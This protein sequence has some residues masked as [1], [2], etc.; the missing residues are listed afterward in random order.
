MFCSIPILD[1]ER[2]RVGVTIHIRGIL[3]LIK[4]APDVCF[5]TEALM[6]RDY[7]VGQATMGIVTHPRETT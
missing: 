2:T 6:P 5:H 4:Y 1:S 3:L 7:R